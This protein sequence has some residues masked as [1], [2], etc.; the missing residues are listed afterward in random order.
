MKVKGPDWDHLV[1][2]GELS[3]YSFKGYWITIDTN[4]HFIYANET[5]KGV[6]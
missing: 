2:S 4:K 1:K 3:A 5:W 6:K